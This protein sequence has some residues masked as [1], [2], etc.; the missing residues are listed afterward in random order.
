MLEMLQNLEQSATRLHSTTQI[1]C[2]LL[3]LALGLFIWLG[4][5][6]FRKLLL[7]V[8]GTACGIIFGLLIASWNILLGIA[9]VGVG[10]IGS[11]Y[12]KEYFLA[13]IATFIAAILGF[14]TLITPYIK[15]DDEIFKILQQTVNIVPPYNWALL[16][17]LIALP[18]IA[19][20]YLWRITFAVLS[21][22]LGS[23]LLL[24]AVALLNIRIRTEPQQIVSQNPLRMLIILL[25]VAAVGT[26][27]QLVSPKVAAR[28]KTGKIHKIK[29]NKPK[30]G[31]EAEQQDEDST[32]QSSWRTA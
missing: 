22:T 11:I 27:I 32:A 24:A 26:A 9:L 31:K 21:S 25:A 3:A 2:A 16:L 12:L 13:I 20:Y 7:I 15:P 4:G 17:L 29:P 28:F 18:V 23:T 8:I 14:T 30:K 10:I 19:G 1:I 6:G 5:F